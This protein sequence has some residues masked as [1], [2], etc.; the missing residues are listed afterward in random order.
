MRVVCGCGKNDHGGTWASE[1]ISAHL[2]GDTA[3][4]IMWFS[5]SESVHS[6]WSLGLR[7]LLSSSVWFPWS[8]T[9]GTC[10]C[11]FYSLW[12]FLSGLN[13]HYHLRHSLCAVAMLCDNISSKT[14]ASP[15]GQ[16]LSW[17]LWKCCFCNTT[18]NFGS[19]LLQL[20]ALRGSQSP[21][22]CLT[23]RWFSREPLPSVFL[24]VK[25][26]ED[27][28]VGCSAQ[29]WH[30]VLLLLSSKVTSPLM[31]VGHLLWW[32]LFKMS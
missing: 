4:S 32:L 9:R 8:H 6:G 7:S 27:G 16:V 29:R 30:T 15:A 25:W 2:L 13:T 26:R 21:H 20:A 22:R 28:P 3:P 31:S 5:G 1:L 18:V 23:S 11:P 24:F 12:Y 14:R 17:T 10:T 19:E